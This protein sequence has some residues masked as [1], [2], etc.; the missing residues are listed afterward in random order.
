MNS[1]YCIE[2]LDKTLQDILEKSQF[3]GKSIILSGDFGQT[4]PVKPGAM[5]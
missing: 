4:I 1:H 3:G 2:T 5:K